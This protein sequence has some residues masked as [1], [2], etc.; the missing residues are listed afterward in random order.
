MPTSYVTTIG[1]KVLLYVIQVSMFCVIVLWTNMRSGDDCRPGSREK[2]L[3]ELVV[4]G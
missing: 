2:P 1:V 3:N 4:L